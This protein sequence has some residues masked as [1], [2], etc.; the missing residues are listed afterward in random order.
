MLQNSPQT[1]S[2]SKRTRFIITGEY[3]AIHT[4]VEH[5]LMIPHSA[6][7]LNNYEQQQQQ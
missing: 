6:T 4:F 1:F 2:A 5:N 3:D 7:K